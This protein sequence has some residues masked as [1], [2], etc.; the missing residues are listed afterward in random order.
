MYT[1]AKQDPNYVTGPIAQ[2]KCPCGQETTHAEYLDR[3]RFEREC[4]HALRVSERPWASFAAD[5][6]AHV[7]L[8]YE[9]A[10]MNAE[11]S[12]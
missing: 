12:K 8:A 6:H 9:R 11:V 10:A 3:A 7:A 1:Y 2:P 4:E 5:C